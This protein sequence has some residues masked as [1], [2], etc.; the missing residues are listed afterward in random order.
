MIQLTV[1]INFNL[2]VDEKT[3]SYVIQN[4][5]IQI[6]T[7]DEL[8]LEMERK[9]N[10]A[11]IRYGIFTLGSKSVI[12]QILPQD[13]DITVIYDQEAYPAHTHKTNPGRIDRLS[14]LVKHFHV[15]TELALKYNTAKKELYVTKIK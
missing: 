6:Q 4:Q 9:L 15:N 2:S 12:G 8:P 3:N 10:V 1:N 7:P 13:T 11:E 5:T 14:A